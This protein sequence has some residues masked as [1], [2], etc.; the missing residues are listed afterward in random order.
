MHID[1]SMSAREIVQV[2]A[3]VFFGFWFFVAI[4]IAVADAFGFFD[5]VGHAE[6]DGVWEHRRGEWTVD[7]GIEDHP[8]DDCPACR[9]AVR[10]RWS[11]KPPSA[12][13]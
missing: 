12:K 5:H 4:V 6:T 3:V 9:R 8:A 2:F 7:E 1:P 11:A 13:P 10:G